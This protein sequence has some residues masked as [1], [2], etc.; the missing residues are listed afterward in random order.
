MAQAGPGFVIN[1]GTNNVN[2]G[3]QAAAAA[4]RSKRKAEVLEDEADGKKKTRKKRE[5]RDPDAPKRPASSY[6][7]YQNEVRKDIKEKNPGLS[8][9]EILAI[10]GKKWASLSDA[11]KARYNVAN[12]EAKAKYL[13]DKAAYDAKQSTDAESP[14]QSEPP[15]P[16]VRIV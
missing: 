4:G 16:P 14:V 2:N 8:N 1:G 7:L 11:D 12:S 9:S 5:P 6:I 10:I 15:P 13:T 3:H